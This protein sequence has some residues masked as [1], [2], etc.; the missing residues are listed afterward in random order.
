MKNRI[1]R[2]L[3]LFIRDLNRNYSLSRLSPA[4]FSNIKEF[5]S[6]DGKRIRPILFCIG[7]L[8]FSKQAPFGL[9]RSALSLEL[10]HD[11]MLVHDDIIDKSAMRRGKPSMHVLLNK[12]LKHAKNLKFNGDDLAIAIGDVMYAMALDAFLAVRERPER[13]ELALR[14]LISAAL[15]TG[16]GEFIELLLGIKPIEQISKNDIYKI[17][18]YKTANY[19]FASPLAMGAVLAGAKE[20]QIKKLFDYG[21][22][23]GCAFQIKDDIIGTFGESQETGKSNLTD[24]KEA[25]RTLLVWHA[26]NHCDRKGKAAI[27]KVFSGEKTGKKELF[28]IRRL[29]SAAGSLDY[30][31]GEIKNLLLQSER[32]I[33]ALKMRKNYRA[34]LISFSRKILSV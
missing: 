2:E 32:I 31:R 34:A 7:Y 22:L 19:T 15:Y 21:M 24:I 8:G 3:S 4:L 33:T 1:E 28:K 16:S 30:A 27:K 5:L 10:L 17:Y 13:K 12:Y 20:R 6:R 14:K 25:K 29:L 26:Y 9:Y 11:F 23:L 18:A